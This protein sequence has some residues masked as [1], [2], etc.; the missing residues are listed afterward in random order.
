MATAP[1]LA[2]GS[3]PRASSATFEKKVELS[4]AGSNGYRV[5]VSGEPLKGLSNLVMVSAETPHASVTYIAPG[6]VSETSMRA[7]LV[8]LGRIRL[9]Y[10]P[11]GKA[12]LK[13][14]PERCFIGGS[15]ESRTRAIAP[16][17]GIV[18]FRGEGGYTSVVAHRARGAIHEKLTCG[19]PRETHSH[20]RSHF[21]L[22]VADS[23]DGP[24]FSA[25]HQISSSSLTGTP[26]GG[27]IGFLALEFQRDRRIQIFRVA[28]VNG[29][30]DDFT[31]DSALTTATVTPPPPFS[32]SAQFERLP[33]GSTSWT[34]SLSVDFPGRGPVPLTGPFTKAELELE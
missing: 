18:R 10:H 4:L 8:A 23:K 2:A 3:F 24:L 19:E 17:H 22:L 32:G 33:D 21:P 6:H 26:N 28:G 34:G 20:D 14:I 15:S 12:P 31:Y 5:T 9:K 13:D 30:P 11:L 27:K 25:G 7:N 29:P 16:P 1:A